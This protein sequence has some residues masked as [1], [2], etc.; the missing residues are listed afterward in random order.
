MLA[1]PDFSKPFIILKLK[2]IRKADGK[3]VARALEEL[4][5]FRWEMPEYLLTD[6]VR[7]FDNQT[8]RRSWKNTG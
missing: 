7:E 6:N 4:I 2:A 1:R 8:L 5:L 3:S